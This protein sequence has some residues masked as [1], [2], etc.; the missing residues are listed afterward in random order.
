M[1]SANSRIGERDVRIPALRAMA[2][3]PHGEIKTSKLIGILEDEFDPAGEDAAIL[4]NRRDTKFS[5]IVRNLVSH[6]GTSTN[7]FKRGL[8]TYDE[9]NHTLRITD[10]GRA[11][12]AQL[13]DE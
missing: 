13:D 10:E 1:A 8:A 3:E 9:A 6:Q 11:F 12:L 7:L 5:Q 2:A 4:D